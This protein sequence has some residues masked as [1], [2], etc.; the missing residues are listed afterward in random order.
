MFA[1]TKLRMLE[2]K[3]VYNT[4]LIDRCRGRYNRQFWRI[5]SSI[6]TS[7]SSFIHAVSLEWDEP[8][9]WSNHG[10]TAC[11]FFIVGFFLKNRTFHFPFSILVDLPGETAYYRNGM[12]NQHLH[13]PKISKYIK[14]KE[15]MPMPK[16]LIFLEHNL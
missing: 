14:L 3:S 4:N 5:R 7:Q 12:K 11:V 1:L 6:L 2:N 13:N 10:T 8:T 16:D 9:V 15:K